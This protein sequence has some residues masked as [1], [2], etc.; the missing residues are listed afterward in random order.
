MAERSDESRLAIL[1][2]R[3]AIL[4]A[5]DEQIELFH[6]AWDRAEP[7]ARRLMASMGDKHLRTLIGSLEEVDAENPE[8]VV[9]LDFGPHDGDRLAELLGGRIG[10]VK[11]WVGQDPERAQAALE[12]EEQFQDARPTLVRWLQTAAEQG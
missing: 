3:L 12:M 4:Q 11:A 9:S 6:Q 5:T 8:P 2:D 1:D 7:S 10:P